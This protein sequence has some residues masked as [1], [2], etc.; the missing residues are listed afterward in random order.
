MTG[1]HPP[2]R[3]QPREVHLVTASQSSS[4]QQC[5]LSNYSVLVMVF[6]TKNTYLYCLLSFS[7]FPLGQS[8][9]PLVTPLC[10]QRLEQLCL[11]HNSLELVFVLLL[12][13][14]YSEMKVPERVLKCFS[15]IG[16]GSAGINK[17]FLDH[18]FNEPKFILKIFE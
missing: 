1:S 5:T 6:I 13:V 2:F 9:Y 18:F 8:C 15:Q 11:V 14:V 12:K 3:S 7:L 17:L 16:W 10:P 4:H